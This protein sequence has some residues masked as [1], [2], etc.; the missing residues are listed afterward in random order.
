VIKLPKPRLPAEALSSAEIAVRTPR[1]DVCVECGA[2]L[3]EARMALVC[4]TCGDGIHPSCA[5]R[6]ERGEGWGNR[7]LFCPRCA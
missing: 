1:P 2:T 5:G 3:P 4:G 7:T 6:V